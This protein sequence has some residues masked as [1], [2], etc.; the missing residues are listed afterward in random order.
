MARMSLFDLIFFFFFV[1]CS[2]LFSALGSSVLGVEYT[3]IVPT[4]SSKNAVSVLIENMSGGIYTHTS[5]SCAGLELVGTAIRVFVRCIDQAVD[6][7]A[8]SA[9]RAKRHFLREI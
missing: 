2:C 6:V 7:R 9:C 1:L 4:S 3:A 5:K 8:A